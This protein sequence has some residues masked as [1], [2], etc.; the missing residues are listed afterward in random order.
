[1]QARIASRLAAAALLLMGLAALPARAESPSAVILISLD[2]T[3]PADIDR[4]DLPTFAELRRRGAQASRL[5]TV[6]PSNTFPSHV[7]LVTG[8]Y[9]DVHG[10]VNN[11]FVDPERGEF[12]KSDDPR[13]LL[14]E[15][16]WS[17]LAEQG[18][19][20]AAFHWVGSEGAWSSGRGPRYWKK[21]DEKVGAKAKVDQVLAWLSGPEPRPRLITVWLPGAD[22]QAHLMGMETPPVQRALAAQ[23]KQLGRLIAGLDERGAFAHTTLL[24]VSDHG[25]GPVY[26]RIDLAAGLRAAGVKAEVIGAG[27]MA[28]VRVE[29]G[30]GFGDRAVSVARGLGLQAWP[31]ELAPAELHARH[32]RFGDV[33]V[34]APIGVAIQSAGSTPMYGA[35][36]Y[37]PEE[38]WMG[39]LFLAVGRGAQPGAQLGDL[40]SLD[41]APTILRLLG[42]EVPDTMQGRP[43]ASLLPAAGATATAAK[44]EQP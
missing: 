27:G 22:K 41:V 25:M 20:S 28:T 13:W 16:L 29:K 17:L 18:V 23:D 15:P 19:A 44:E 36:G 9:P 26:R 40:R 4:P 3:R 24:I 21:F 6:F 2:G 11:D 7:T 43:I 30:Q 37:R 39:A 1:M 5:I 33:V 42:L 38:S 8:V 12:H 35:H 14:A 31:R 34:L 32:P 10:I